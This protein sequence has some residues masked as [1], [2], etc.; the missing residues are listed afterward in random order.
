M[1]GFTIPEYLPGR[2]A[3]KEAGLTIGHIQQL[4]YAR[5]IRGVLRGNHWYIDVED[6]ATLKRERSYFERREVCLRLGITEREFYLVLEKGL[7]VPKNVISVI[8]L[9]DPVDVAACHKA[10]EDSFSIEEAATLLDRSKRTIQRMIAQGHLESIDTVRGRRV[11][12]SAIVT[13]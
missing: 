13:E 4:A 6:V 3:A 9:F 11:P 8:T 7:L 2:E 1:E 12:R 5:R 10:V